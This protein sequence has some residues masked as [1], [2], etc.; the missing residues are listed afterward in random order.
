MD[1]RDFSGVSYVGNLFAYLPPQCQGQ[2]CPEPVARLKCPF[3]SCPPC[4]PVQADVPWW[5]PAS[6]FE[7]YN[8]FPDGALFSVEPTI[9][10]LFDAMAASGPHS[11]YQE[12]A[13]QM[14]LPP[15]EGCEEASASSLALVSSSSGHR[16]ALPDRA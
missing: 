11:A 3:L 14:S 12:E 10:V 5:R 2:L 1:E 4:E 16:L 15:F 7:G 9:P 8:A 6:W 13:A